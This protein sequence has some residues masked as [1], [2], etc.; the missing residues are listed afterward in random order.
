MNVVQAMPPTTKYRPRA[1]PIATYSQSGR[2]LG[3]RCSCIC[4]T[5]ISL[6]SS[7]QCAPTCAACDS[8]MAT[9]ATLTP[10]SQ[11]QIG[12]DRH[13]RRWETAQVEA[14]VLLSV[15]VR[16]GPFRTAVTGTLVAR[17]FRRPALGGAVGSQRNGWVRPVLGNHCFVGKPPEGGAA[18]RYPPILTCQS[19][20][21]SCAEVAIRV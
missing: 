13:L 12:Q 11:S 20:W 14:A 16:W 4:I 19:L 9:S 17:S 1:A 7:R 2:P 15:A 5:S 6:G 21:R 3:R 18:V 8:S 10:C